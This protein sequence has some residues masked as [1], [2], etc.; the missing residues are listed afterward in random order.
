MKSKL[1]GGECK[2]QLSGTERLSEKESDE[3]GD[4]DSGDVI[5]DKWGHNGETTDRG[6][7]RDGGSEDSVGQGQSCSKQGLW[8]TEVESAPSEDAQLKIR[9]QA[10]CRSSPK[11]IEATDIS[12]ID[13]SRTSHVEGS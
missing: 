1:T 3:E 9:R 7:D 8:D 11:S 12:P 4:G 6:S 10:A 2:G 5:G 13:P